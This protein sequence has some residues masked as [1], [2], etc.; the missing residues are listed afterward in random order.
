MKGGFYSHFTHDDEKNA[1]PAN[2]KRHLAFLF[3]M[4]RR[5]KKP[6]FTALAMTLLQAGTS[7]APPLLAR[8]AIDEHILT[9]QFAGLT[10]LMGLYVTLYLAAWF[11]TY[12]QRILTQKAGQ[13]AI[14]D[15]R[16]RLFNKILSLP[17]SYHE[18]Q[19]KGGMT[20]LIMNDVNALSTA[21]TDGVISLI[22]DL[23][24]LIAIVFIMYRLHPDLTFLLMATLPIILIAMGL[25]SGQIR[26]A[27]RDV[28]EKMADLNTQVEENFSGIRVVQSLGVQQ[29]QEQDFVQVNQ[30]N[31]K[32]GMRAMV[33]LALI[34]PV[35][36]L[37]AGSGTAILLWFGGLHVMEGTISLGVFV[38]FLAYLRKFYQPVRNM[39][40]LYHTY[41]SAMASLD[42]LTGVLEYPDGTSNSRLSSTLSTMEPLRGDICF[43]QVGFSYSSTSASP[44]LE[45]VSFHVRPGERIGIAG[46]TGSGKSTMVILLTGLAN[47]DRGE[48]LLDGIPLSHLPP[49]LIQ[50]TIAVV[51]QT[52]F[53]FSG[54]IADNIRFGRPEATDREIMAV[55]K[56]MEAHEMIMD[57]ENAYETVVGENGVG[58]SGGQQQLVA[59]ARA[60]IKDAPVLILDEA[61]AS[62]DVGLE[63]R[64]QRGIDRMTLTHTSLVIAHRLSTLASMDRIYYLEN[65]IIAAH[66]THSEL[67]ANCVP[68]SQMVEKE[69]AGIFPGN[70][71]HGFP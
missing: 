39:S 14:H 31:L 12:H 55:C 51:P 66:G 33:M 64:L 43:H 47:P 62:M 1:T 53:L 57:L 54:T 63:S 10:R 4:I 52:P 68:Y 21:V 44:V 8:K 56:K 20:S 36:S 42:R 17:L 37:T 13:E 61:T 16:M 59:L 30:V 18:S 11:F 46:S 58:L 48:I 49:A 9:G 67:L 29:S 28:R 22:S 50:R 32:A 25:L 27:F 26:R 35:T 34:F 7:L 40:D 38:A 15:V 70:A 19:Q 69:S 45:N 3:Q 6:L 24:T 2:P 60:L 71:G 23:A 5:Q 65:G 41:L